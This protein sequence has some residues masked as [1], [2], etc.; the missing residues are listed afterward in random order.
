MSRATRWFGWIFG[1]ATL[2]L[3]FR[4]FLASR[5]EL[6]GYEFEL[7]PLCAGAAIGCFALYLLGRCLVWH[8]LMRWCGVGEGWAFDASAW[9]V[10]V[11]LGKFI[12][13]RVALYAGRLYW[14]RTSR[15]SRVTLSICFLID[16]MGTAIGASLVILLACL[17]PHPKGLD[18]YRLPAALLSLGAVAFMHP[19][20]LQ[21][22][23]DT[24][25]RLLG[26][27]RSRIPL[28]AWQIVTFTLLL[29]I[30]W[31][32]M[33]AGAFFS[34]RTVLFVPAEDFFFV[35]AAFAVSSISGMLAIFTPGG[36]GVREGLFAILL[37][38]L[39]PASMAS[40]VAL[41]SRLWFTIAE[42]SVVSVVYAIHWSRRR[43]R[44]TPGDD[45]AKPDH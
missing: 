35:C 21:L 17:L 45:L 5:A 2:A 28:A 29:A 1:L 36:L 11:V 7:D 12:P 39:V 38:T 18:P 22:A 37:G 20:L 42:L 43:E 16:V 3:L 10:S 6:A 25:N 8:L 32:F 15:I 34:I 23:L 24:S 41:L 26:R 33:G 19:R 13:G 30:D 27:D 31:L 4:Y 40:L 44:P 9:L 14:Y